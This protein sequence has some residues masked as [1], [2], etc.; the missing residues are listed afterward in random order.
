MHQMVQV[1][2]ILNSVILL[3]N[4]YKLVFHRHLQNSN[5]GFRGIVTQNLLKIYQ[6]I[7]TKRTN[8]R[9]CFELLNWCCEFCCSGILQIRFSE[10]KFMITSPLNYNN[11]HEKTC[12]T[13]QAGLVFSNKGI[14]Q[15]KQHLH[16]I[17]SF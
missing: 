11:L 2:N 15:K 4:S 16:T 8:S 12:K 3:D 14:C 1:S 6:N 13:K 10:D 17:H 7:V 9:F 5:R